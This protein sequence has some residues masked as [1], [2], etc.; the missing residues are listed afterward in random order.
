MTEQARALLLKAADVQE[1]NGLH[2]QG[3]YDRMQQA[4]D[5]PDPR[6]CRVCALGAISTAAGLYPN[7]LSSSYPG[8][9]LAREAARLLADH[10]VK[11]GLAKPPDDGDPVRTV[12]VNWADKP[13]QTAGSIAAV[14][15]ATA[16]A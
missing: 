4:L 8:A 9:D 10:L 14:M 7:E 12:G 2:Q 11:Q 6:K 15:R 16:T 3:W 5:T 1:A 13:G